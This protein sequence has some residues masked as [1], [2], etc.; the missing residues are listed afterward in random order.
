L[1]FSTTVD[2]EVIVLFIVIPVVFVIA[3]PIVIV[4]LF[5]LQFNNDLGSY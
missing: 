1:H 4:T 2:L 5:L 3:I